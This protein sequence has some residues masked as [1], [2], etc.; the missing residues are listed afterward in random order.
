M[1]IEPTTTHVRLLRSGEDGESSAARQER[2]EGRVRRHSA[3]TPRPLKKVFGIICGMTVEEIVNSEAFK[4][5]VEDYRSMCF[6]NMDADFFPSNK[7]EVLLALDNLEKY[8]DMKSY[9][10]AGEVRKWL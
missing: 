1:P 4:S 5:V 2:R 10:F 9:R 3:R 8:G 7:R 6:W